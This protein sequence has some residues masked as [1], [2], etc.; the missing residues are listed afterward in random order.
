MKK[1]FFSMTLKQEKK[2]GKSVEDFIQKA[3]ERFS[4]KYDYSK[5]LYRGIHVK[6]KIICPEHGSFEET[7]SSHLNHK[8]CPKCID[9]SSRISSIIQVLRKRNVAYVTEKQFDS[10]IDPLTEKHLRFDIFLPAYAACIEYDE[11]SATSEQ[12]RKSFKSQRIKD[13]IVKN[14]KSKYCQD[15]NIK[16]LRIPFTVSEPNALVLNFI[17]TLEFNRYFYSQADF[18]RDIVKV[19]NH[20][21]TL[22]HEKV[23]I[24]G[25]LRGSLILATYL[26]YSLGC[27][28]IGVLRYQRYDGNDTRVKLEIKH[29]EDVTAIIIVDDLID[30]GITIKKSISFLKR[31]FP[32]IPVYSVVLFG[33]ENESKTIYM[34]QH[35][36][37]WIEF[38]WENS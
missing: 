16:L 36:K 25:I 31:R 38:F 23:A 17:K 28:E 21:R 24:Y 27:K 5:I 29:T 6:C 20:I 35:P 10:C 12:V 18:N 32:K 13:Q 2:Y 15:E 8:G 26:S 11:E 37:K 34:N 33:E 1:G 30:S 3:N 4:F 22:G 19:K 14:I 9:K 7:P